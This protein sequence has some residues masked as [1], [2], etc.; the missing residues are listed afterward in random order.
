M[1]LRAQDASSVSLTLDLSPFLYVVRIDI[2]FHLLS[3]SFIYAVILSVVL[4]SL[5]TRI[6]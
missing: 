5:F 4:L 3:I 2:L 6:L 1:Y